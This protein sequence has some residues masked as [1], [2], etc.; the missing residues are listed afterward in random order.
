MSTARTPGENDTIPPPPEHIPLLAKSTT[1]HYSMDKDMRPNSYN[2][3]EGD[4]EAS[5]RVKQQDDDD[6]QQESTL[7]VKEAPATQQVSGNN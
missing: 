1:S 5:I 6:K 4:C 2:R 7:I 3:M